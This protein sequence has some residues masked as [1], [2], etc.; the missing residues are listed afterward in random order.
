MNWNFAGDDWHCPSAEVDLKQGG[1]FSSRME[2]KDGSFGFD[3]WGIY[4]EIIPQEKIK[5]TMGDGR[6]AVVR[7]TEVNGNTLVEIDFEPE[8]MNP[9]EM[10]QEGWQ[11]ILNH[12]KEY[13]ESK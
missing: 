13:A 5:Y 11:A 2:A 1:K 4:D 9:E 6:K 8:N 10:Q 3:F 12:F 7:F